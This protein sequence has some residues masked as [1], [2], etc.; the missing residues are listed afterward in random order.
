MPLN[1]DGWLRG[2]KA[3]ATYLD[4]HPTG[5]RR[6]F[7]RYGGFPARFDGRLMIVNKEELNAWVKS[8]TKRVCP[9]DE[10]PCIK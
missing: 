7:K 1:D 6:L 4:I 10:T 2:K 9:Y 3:I 8:N 5:V